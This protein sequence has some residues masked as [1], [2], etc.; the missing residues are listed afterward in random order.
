MTLHHAADPSAEAEPYLDTLGNLC[1][2]YDVDAESKYVELDGPASRVHYLTAGEGPPLLLLH[3][4]GSTAAVWIPLLD[5]L[6][7]HFTVYVPERPGRGLSSAV[8]YRKTGFRHFSVDYVADFL[9]SLGIDETAVMGNSLGGFQALA[10]AVDYPE[11]V[12]KLCLV[13]APAGLSRS[14]PFLFRLFDV[15]LF[16]RWLFDYT[17]AETIP[18]ARAAARRLDV[19]DDSALPDCYFEVGLL[20]EQLPGQHES[21]W[22]LLEALGTFRGMRQR[23]DLREKLAGSEIPTRFVWGTE[24]YFWPPDVGEETVEAMPNAELVVLDG[25]GHVP[26]LEPNAAAEEAVVEFLAAE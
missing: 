23:F 22:S 24:D 25:E 16:G 5:A 2:Y 21:L 18:E 26:W 14:V 3:G 8:D 10:L 4:L 1:D 19:V 17:T 7:D 6:T 9:D 13:G 20:G 11:R 12:Q 15:P